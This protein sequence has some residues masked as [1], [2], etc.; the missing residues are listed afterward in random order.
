M[1]PASTRRPSPSDCSPRSGWR[2]SRARHSGRQAPG[3]C[4]PATPPPTRRLSRPWIAWSDSWP[5]AAPPSLASLAPRGC[6]CRGVHVGIGQEVEDQA[7]E[8]LWLLEVDHVRQPLEYL[9]TGTGS[10]LGTLESGPV[11][12]ARVRGADVTLAW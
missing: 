1:P 8:A 7:G 5:T 6:G 12:A 11:S 2:S 4:G 9:A 10:V 3:T